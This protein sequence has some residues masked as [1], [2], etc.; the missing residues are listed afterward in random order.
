M[1]M[2]L[3]KVIG[4][5]NFYPKDVTRKHVSQSTWKRSALIQTGCDIE[6]YY[7]WFLEKRFNL[8]LNQTIRG[9]HVTFINDK[10]QV[11]EWDRYAKHFHGKEITFYHE[12]EPLSD[13]KHWWLRVH[14]P[15]A[16]SIRVACGLE[17]H[18]YYG[19]HLTLGYAN[20]K[21]IDHS[22]YILKQAKRF[23]LIHYE[24]RK[25]IDSYEIV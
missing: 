1:K 14:S 8:T 21:N 4:K 18:P 25:P 20:E 19:L 6:S 7:A 2:K 16:E 5:L 22:E 12:L 24:Q 23:G 3:V 11:D 15:E 9:T 10:F 13:G 17:R